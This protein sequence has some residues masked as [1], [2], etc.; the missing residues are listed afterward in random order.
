MIHVNPAIPNTR[1][2]RLDWTEYSALFC[3][4]ATITLEKCRLQTQ[5][6]LKLLTTLR[7]RRSLGTTMAS[8]KGKERLTK[9]HFH[10]V[11]VYNRY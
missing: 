5:A 11:S 4:D 2:W 3:S 10:N 1:K 7:E 6:R 8:S 9:Q